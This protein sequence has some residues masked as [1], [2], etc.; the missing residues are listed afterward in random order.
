MTIVLVYWGYAL[1][2]PLQAIY[3]NTR[4]I[5]WLFS[6]V[7]WDMPIEK[8][9][10][11]IKESINY[12]IT[13]DALR[14]FIRRINFTHVVVRNVKRFYTSNRKSDHTSKLKDIDADVQLIKAFL[15][16]KI[17]TTYAEATAASDENL[18]EMD[19]SNW[20]GLRNV[21]AKSPWHE[22]RRTMQDYRSYVQDEVTKLCPWHHWAP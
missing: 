22:M 6:H 18:L 16:A 8:L 17:G 5:R 19:L 7:G 14:T 12:K 15:R 10:M 21:R 13:E 11:W 20:G 2:E 9:N 4:T 1:L 3:H